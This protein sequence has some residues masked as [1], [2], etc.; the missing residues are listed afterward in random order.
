MK[1]S[2]W[3]TLLLGV[4]LLGIGF[5]V[6]YGFQS[7]AAQTARTAPTSAP[8]S[9]SPPLVKG[10]HSSPN[11]QLLAFTGVWDRNSRAGVWLFSMS[12][13]RAQVSPS[14]AGWQDYVSQWRADGRAILL[15][16]EKIP[17]ATA[18]AKAGLFQ[19][20]V[21]AATLR[22]GELQSATPPLPSN[23]TVVSGSY[24]PDGQVLVKTRRQPK[25][26]FLA[27]GEKLQLLDRSP[28]SYGQNRPVER[29][30]HVVVF[31]V[32]DVPQAQG[33]A[34]YRIENG[35]AQQLSQPM[36][37]VS[38]S[39]VSP[40]A[41]WL[42]VAREDGASSEGEGRDFVWTLYAI[43]DK[44]VR[45]LK[46]QSVPA[47]AISVYWSPDE[48]QILGA[49]GQK[50]W[51]VSV[52]DLRVRQIGSKSDWNADD[53]TWIGNQNAVAVAASGKL[54]RVDCATGKAQELWTFPKEFWD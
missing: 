6:G 17:R 34:L 4:G 53:A 8:S 7:R 13:R 35:R 50:L 1:R 11:G 2:A 9:S 37:D 30:G 20:K 44:S 10:L 46:T 52:P 40:S 49:A 42:V 22:S 3:G 19:A 33:V 41:R 21:D 47:D 15:E 38:W 26:L 51:S 32:R 31:A 27:Q 5:I 48:K 12:S 54:W 24:A 25:S 23:E 14:P 29:G 16:R 43:G 28:N 39:Y 45:E 18:D 36:E